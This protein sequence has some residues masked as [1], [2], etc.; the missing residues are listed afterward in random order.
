MLQVQNCYIFQNKCK[1]LLRARNIA[2]TDLLKYTLEVL[3]RYQSIGNIHGTIKNCGNYVQVKVKIVF[4]NHFT[5]S[6]VHTVF[7]IYYFL[8]YENVRISINQNFATMYTAN[9]F[10]ILKTGFLIFLQGIPVLLFSILV[11]ILIFTVLQC[12]LERKWYFVT[13]IVLT[14][15][16]K[17]LF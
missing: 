16:E 9:S 4:A 5:I 8:W 1:K 7:Q 3:I 17:E 12:V 14:Y 6:R 11:P 15:C 2:L 10:L 13:K